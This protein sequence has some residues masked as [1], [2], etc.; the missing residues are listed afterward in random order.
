MRA[1]VHGTQGCL[2][3]TAWLAC[4]HRLAR[5]VGVYVLHGALCTCLLI[6]SIVL[7]V[8]AVLPPQLAATTAVSATGTTTSQ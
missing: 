6:R 1:C 2:W 3:L 4:T 7:P 5:A 8:L